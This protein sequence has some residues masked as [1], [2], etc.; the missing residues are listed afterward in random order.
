MRRGLIGAARWSGHPVKGGSAAT[1]LAE[2]E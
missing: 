1:P 2:H